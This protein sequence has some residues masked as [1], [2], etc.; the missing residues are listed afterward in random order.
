MKALLRPILRYAEFHGRASRR[1]FWLFAALF[2]ALNFAANWID[3]LD[4]ERTIVAARMGI[5]ELAV[6]IALL[7]PFLSSG[8]RRLH[9]SG[10]AGWWLVLLYIPYAAWVV[11]AENAQAQLVTQGALLTGFAALVFLLLLPGS[12]GANAYGSR[13]D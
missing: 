7:L 13:T 4:G 12:D 11:S 10:R 3:G 8:T 5:A 2:V 6:T 9:D 1:E